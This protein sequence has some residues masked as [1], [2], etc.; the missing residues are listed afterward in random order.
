MNTVNIC[1]IF[2]IKSPSPIGS[3]QLG[4]QCDGKH[5][6]DIFG[7]VELCT[8]SN[9]EG[10]LGS[11]A[12]LSLVAHEPAQNVSRLLHVHSYNGSCIRLCRHSVVND[13]TL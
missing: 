2:P 6:R 3:V 9:V 4:K 11:S 1:S 8:S 5:Q 7:K 10:I 12:G 13:A